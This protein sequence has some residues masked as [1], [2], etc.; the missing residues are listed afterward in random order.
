ME[1]V[2]NIETIFL[3][4]KQNTI[5]HFNKP[6]WCAVFNFGW[7]K[8]LHCTTDNRFGSYDPIYDVEELKLILE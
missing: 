7:V 3:G 6:A 8:S 5:Y 1:H 2:K 4:G